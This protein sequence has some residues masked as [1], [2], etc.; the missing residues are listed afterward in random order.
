MKTKS[1]KP[2]VSGK[3]S[4]PFFSNQN[5][6]GFFA[7]QAKLKVGVPGDIYEQE[8]DRMADLVVNG[9]SEPE[10]FFAAS[11]PEIQNKTIASDITPLVQ[12]NE[13]EEEVQTRIEL[14]RQP[15]EEEE[16]MVQPKAENSAA[17]S[18]N[19][20][21]QLL[22]SNVGNGNVL[23]SG[24]QAQME[25]G[26]GADF[27]NV[28]IHTDNQ[29][30]Q[31]N[32]ELGAQAFTFGNN[33]F[34]NEGKYDP[35]ST[36][37]KT[38]L[39]HELTHTIQQGASVS[40]NTVQRETAEAAP[41]T[42]AP[43]PEEAAVT[44][45]EST[46]RQKEAFI[47][48]GMYGPKSVSP[49]DTN[50]GGFEASY[51]PATQILQITVRGKTRFVNGLTL[52]SSGLVSS[53][54]ADLAGLANILNYIND[55]TLNNTLVSSYYSW[56]D[57]QKETARINFRQRISE[58]IT[59]W[60]DSPFLEFQVDEP[61]WDDILANVHVSIDVQDEGTASYSGRNNS[62]NDHLQVSL[63][64]NPERAEFGEVRT[65]IADTAQRIG[66]ARLETINTA[67]RLTTGASVDSNRFGNTANTNPYDSEMTLSS[68][69]LL[70]TPSVTNDFNRSM[71]RTSVFF[72]NNEWILDDN[73]KARIDS[74]IGQFR[75][76]DNDTSNSNVTVVGHASILGSTAA[77]R[78]LVNRRINSVMN[79][80]R[81]K[82]FPNIETRVSTENR[83]DTMAEQYDDNENNAAAFRRVQII[84]GTGELQNTVSHEFGHVFGLVDDYVTDD[85]SP[86]GTG[87]PA[88]TVVDH[89][90]M[91]EQIGAG[92]VQSENSDS[93]MSMGNEV[94]GQH[95]GPFGWALKDITNKNWK[96][97]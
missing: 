41:A 48:H 27:S 80:L 51:N 56:S 77:N 21:E 31:M 92:R 5:D 95:Y 66:D 19:S 7:P 94:R 44:C 62:A 50:V 6:T 82:N 33:I 36:S 90:T 73:D 69:S 83:S 30:V 59:L 67:A 91:S 23:A 60:Q 45:D 34:F 37:G 25:N 75:E 74:F 88:G 63:V 42:E 20:T 3:S 13:E 46:E 79:Y 38:L 96:L 84:V 32:R 81:T 68:N 28:N 58:T 64:K 85:L 89:S 43:V 8:A 78:R 54:E 87:T 2:D 70:N 4:K 53:G 29:A 14:Q 97:I 93:M 16:E 12:K 65:L 10:S 57:T 40:K 76:S 86:G 49:T 39:A 61:C 35:Q 22:K 47:N 24:V 26:F 9:Q 11:A 15:E 18:Q 71:L 17:M 55:E 52:G 72:E 1:N